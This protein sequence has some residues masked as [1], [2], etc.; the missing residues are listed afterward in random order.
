MTAN[1]VSKEGKVVRLVMVLMY[2]ELLPVLLLTIMLAQGRVQTKLLD[3]PQKDC[4][5]HLTHAC[6][7]SLCL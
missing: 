1:A 4:R 2:V 5:Y 6:Y 7:A 3:L